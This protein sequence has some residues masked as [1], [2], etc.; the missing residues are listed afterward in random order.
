MKALLGT[1]HMFLYPESMVDGK[2]HTESL[3]ELA[4][5]D[6]VK[7]LDLWLW[8]GERS[9][10]EKR[11]LLDSGTGDGSLAIWD[12]D[13]E[14]IVRIIPNKHNQPIHYAE[15]ANDG[16][17]ILSAAHWGGMKISDAENGEDIWSWHSDSG[18]MTCLTFSPDMKQMAAGGA[19]GKIHIFPI[20]PLQEL[21][22][23]TRERFSNRELS[24]DLKKI[25]YID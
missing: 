9:R 16:K 20:Q 21:I 2:A 11:I 15:F 8:R 24:E 10:E 25:F 3:K 6:R 22:D 23:D 13:T 1:N 4:S 14:S 17:Y 5:T 19:D 7:A 12:M 18:S